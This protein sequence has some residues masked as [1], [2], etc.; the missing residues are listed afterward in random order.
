MGDNSYEARRSNKSVRWS[1]SD[2]HREPVNHS[3]DEGDYF[4]YPNASG[5]RQGQ[6]VYGEEP[7]STD[8]DS[9]DSS[10]N[11][12][13]VSLDRRAA[14]RANTWFN[15][16][17]QSDN[18]IEEN[19]PASASNAAASSSS[20]SSVPQI[21]VSEH[22]NPYENIMDIGTKVSGGLAPGGAE[23]VADDDAVDEEYRL[24][25]NRLLSSLGAHTESSSP[26][27]MD[28]PDPVNL[29]AIPMSNLT[30]PG[31]DSDVSS[32][33]SE[34][35][36]TSDIETPT[37]PQT[38]SR[39]FHRVDSAAKADELRQKLEKT[40]SER[41]KRMEQ[42]LENR[43]SRSATP[44]AGRSSSI[45]ED[46]TS[47]D[48]KQRESEDSE[49]EELR[50]LEEAARQEAELSAKL[51]VKSHLNPG[52][53][54]N[55]DDTEKGYV[56]NLNQ[57]LLDEDELRQAAEARA[58]ADKAKE[59]EQQGSQAADGS[60][61]DTLTNEKNESQSQKSGSDSDSESDEENKNVSLR[62]DPDYVPPP[63]KVKEG[64]LGSLLRLY[65]GQE[66][67]AKSTGSTGS[68]PAETPS[69]SPLPSPSEAPL[70][71]EIPGMA[72]NSLHP[73]SSGAGGVSNKW[74]RPDVFRSKSSEN[75]R[76][77]GESLS[78]W[79][80]KPSHGKAPSIG[81][82]ASSGLATAGGIA[83][84]VAAAASDA[85]ADIRKRLQ[86]T[87]KDGVKGF[88]EISHLRHKEAKKATRRAE[89]ERKEKA[90]ALKKA[91][92]A[93][94]NRITVHIAD[95]LQRQRF[96]LRLGR[97]LMLFGAPSH[98]LEEYLKITARVLEID[99]QVLY[100]PGCLLF[101]FGDAT[102]HTSETKLL[103][104]T[105]GLNLQKLH[106]THLIYKEV[107]HD[108]MSLEEASSHI[109]HLLRTKNI[110]PWWLVVFFYGLACVCCGMFAYGGLWKDMP[111]I[112]F[113]G[114]CVG[115]LQFWVQP[116][117]DLYANV[118]EVSSSIVV[119]FLGRAFGSIG[120]KDHRVFC[121][122][123]IVQ[124]SLAL[125]LPGYIILVGALELQTKNLV[126]GSVRMF[127]ANIY[128]LFLSFGITLG[129]TIYGWIDGGATD[130]TTCGAA[131]K[132]PEEWKILFV[133]MATL[134]MAVVNQ[135]G[136]RQLPVM[137][138]IGSA[139]YTAQYFVQKKVQNASSFTSAIGAFTLGILGN[140][141]SRVGHGL[142]FAAMLPGIF[143]LV[144]SGIAAQGSLVAG[145]KVANEIVNSTR[146][147][148]T[149][150]S[151]S[152]ESSSQ[153]SAISELGNS[154]TQVA[155]GIVVGLFA[156]TL[157]VYPLG[158]KKKRSGLFTF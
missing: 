93:E 111:I 105:Q 76:H 42:I 54:D 65:A 40:Q 8:S 39:Q 10:D 50:Q 114:S 108:L 78:K 148:S 69:S 41:S 157:V 126:A 86:K 75:L 73:P 130:Q 140:L 138:V 47:V 153:S 84:D 60:S 141:Y 107:V 58:E 28:V 56:P 21:Q 134:F 70:T 122:S 121:F 119:S 12:D 131:S 142:A 91:R 20:T 125:I 104:V 156:A 133:P 112:F 79:L 129:S 99:C 17:R 81:Y 146:T 67:D 1:G 71:P 51:L 3:T 9:S 37:R 64:V 4:T 80:K 11:S 57:T 100:I 38:A 145:V 98:R 124:A 30:P 127:Y 116:K 139:G 15:Q 36:E 31:P 14:T 118:F 144:P 49:E 16:L 77:G 13:E 151:S 6:V 53:L 152:N 117:S 95:V 154:M 120:H 5:N 46:R 43:R 24:R 115:F 102:T 94:Q 87:E 135:A 82:L 147:N 68:T 45:Q 23:G 29:S 52:L 150:S 110:Y 155:V 128:S 143:V 113:L 25:R 26:P 109:D 137:V 34:E 74:K 72:G 96:L 90:K 2:D 48:S 158:L 27:Q 19:P 33:D 92:L 97:A 7:S 62:G 66:E 35:D 106:S 132:V 149:S 44:E 101:S 22:L 59:E 85:P 123:S 32:S 103:K 136:M 83:S 63:K 88:D 55:H 89:Q 18:N 61:N